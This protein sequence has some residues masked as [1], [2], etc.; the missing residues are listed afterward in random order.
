MKSY[1]KI[2]NKYLY[3]F[4]EIAAYIPSAP[5]LNE[6]INLFV[7]RITGYEKQEVN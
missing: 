5:P 1:H 2:S 3:Y 6:L 4:K 7:L